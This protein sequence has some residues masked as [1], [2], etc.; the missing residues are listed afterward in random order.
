LCRR[1][2]DNPL[3]RSALLALGAPPRR[4]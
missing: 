2:N 4:R 3:H 1:R